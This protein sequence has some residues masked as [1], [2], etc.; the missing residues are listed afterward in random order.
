MKKL[1]I[2]LIIIVTSTIWSCKKE[3]KFEYA[4]TY[5]ENPF[6]CSAVDMDLIKEATFAYHDF[7]KK[8]YTF[9]QPNNLVEAH[10][11]YLKVAQFNMFPVVEHVDDHMKNIIAALKEKE[12]LW[13]KTGNLYSL[14]YSHE[15]I[16]CI[17]NNLKD[18][19]IKAVFDEML[20]SNTFRTEIILPVILRSP[21]Q[22][23]SDTTLLSYVALDAF[24]ASLLEIDFTMPTDE[25]FNT[26]RDM[27]KTRGEKAKQ[28]LLS[29]E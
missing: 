26:V 13:T 11:N 29:N 25:L 9:R 4:Y 23:L 12:D 28:E 6:N 8:H 24:Y 7:I 17:T 27:N 15:L 21:E 3:P 5:E 10:V 1:S 2:F 20:A 19:S 22:V 16:G 18:E 14:N